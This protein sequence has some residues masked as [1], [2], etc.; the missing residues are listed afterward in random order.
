MTLPNILSFTRILLIPIIFSIIL[1]CTPSRY[2]WLLGIFATAVFLDFLDG[3]IARRLA[4]ESELGRILDPVADKLLVFFSVVALSLVTDFPIWIAIPIVIRDLVILL[5][6]SIMYNRKHL[7]KGSIA[8][9]KITFFLLTLLIYIYIIDL[10]AHTNLYVLK[11]FFSVVSLG[12]LLW[13]FEEY[14][15]VY[16][17]VK[18]NA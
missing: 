13:S 6:S 3:F 5:A 14:F 15:L 1:D 17:R 8:L 18:K 2:P 11:R 7:I 16:S 12:F 4:M 10:G 9:G